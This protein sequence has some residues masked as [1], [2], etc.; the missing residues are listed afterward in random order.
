VKARIGV[1]AGLALVLAREVM[2]FPPYRSTD[3][4]T[5]DPWTIEGRLGLVR[6]TRDHDTN[7]YASPLWRVN[8]GLPHRVELVIEGEWDATGGRLGDAAAGLKA[9]P[10][11]AGSFSLGAE[12]L[13]LLPVS[14][15]GG[16]G[17]EAQLVATQRWER[18]LLHVNGG[19]FL[20][21]RPSVTEKGW[22]ASLL[23][24]AP[25]G[26][27]R[28][29]L[30]LFAKQVNGGP[31]EPSVGGGAIVGLGPIDLRAGVHVGLAD[32]AADLRASLWIAS[33][34]PLR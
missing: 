34:L 5:A 12:V 4:E 25:L 8:L 6:L 22:R 16:A 7:V 9:V 27:W 11:F 19:G 31:L 33:K 14:S 28:P 1:L 30:E 29:G 17:V 21:S 32:A 24:E 18:A 13:G 20:D 26:R 15:A 2:A 23:G 10:F 3:A